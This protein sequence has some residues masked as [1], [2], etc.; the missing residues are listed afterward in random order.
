MKADL[1]IIDFPAL[2]LLSPEMIFDL[3]AGGRR[4]VQRAEGYRATIVSGAVTFEHGEPTGEMPG[5]L[6][7][8]PQAARRAAVAELTT[9]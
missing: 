3:P 4:I 7:R 5:K 6:V 2:R 8:G 1:N 9:T